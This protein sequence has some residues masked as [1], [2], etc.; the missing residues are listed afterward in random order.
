MKSLF[1]V[2]SILCTIA[3]Q[4]ATF[5][6][7]KVGNSS[8]IN[9]SALLEVQGTTGALLV[10]RMSTSQKNA[11]PSPADGDIVYDTTLGEFSGYQG[12]SWQLIGGGIWGS[13]TGTLSNQTDL[14]NALNLKANLASPTFTGTVTAPTF[15]G[16]LTGNASTSTALFGTPTGCTSGQ[17][18]E[19]I[20]SGANLTCAQVNYSQLTGVL[21]NPGPSTLGGI[22]SATGTTHEWISSI[23]TLGVPGFTQP[24][25]GDISGSL[26]SSQLP[27]P[28][29]LSQITTPSNPAS[30]SDSL[31][32]KSDDNLY[33][34]NSS[35][36]ERL[37]GSGIQG[38]NWS[39]SLAIVPNPAAFGTITNSA[40][41][42]RRIG[43]TLEVNGSFIAGTVS[44]GN[45]S[46]ALPSGYV[47]DPTKLN[48]LTN[49]TFLG[50]SFGAVSGAN[51]FGVVTS[52]G[53]TNAVFY[54]GSDTSNVYITD[55]SS[56]FQFTKSTG[57][58]RF[59]SGQL[60][61]F[62]FQIPISGWTTQSPPVPGQAGANFFAS[63]IINSGSSGITSGTFTTFSNSPAFTITPTITG[64]YKVYSAIS[65]QVNNSG[66]PFGVARVYETSQLA[67]LLYES[68][69]PL[70][71]TSTSIST[72][73]VQSVYTLVAG[74]TYVFD[75]QGKF[76]SGN[77]GISID[78]ADAPF[79]MF[80]ELVTG[81]IGNPT[82][83]PG[84]YNFNGYVTASDTNYWSTTASSLSDWTTNGTIPTLNI[85]TNNNFGTVIQA[86][87]Q[88]P[89]ITIISAPRTGVIRV[90]A[91][92]YIYT[93]SGN[94]QVGFNLLETGTA[95]QFG[96]QGGFVATSPQTQ[97]IIGYFPATQGQSYTF[98]IQGYVASG[99]TMFLGDVAIANTQLNWSMEYVQ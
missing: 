55:N 49:G 84:Q 93:P 15:A 37:V 23:S 33:S 50:S 71:T 17:Y 36:S 63:S 22:E 16:A 20:D 52:S 41:F 4:A 43:D 45:A 74:T 95:T 27:D 60:I 26:T 79:Y 59:N 89:A 97:V 94:A 8:P 75:L 10:P 96:L 62:S 87:S 30:G 35:G 21:P 51:P 73:F 70:F 77:L 53:I 88:Q 68:Q 76:L 57:S 13:I 31:Y 80:A 5:T 40:I 90:T 42:S 14:Q 38:S 54:D 25:F 44:T 2:Y 24:A 48:A 29:T 92:L 34:L 47:I 99:V 91:I 66:N 11:I 6:T 98:E 64:T 1:I 7:L 18:A 65:G 78:G 9:A 46:F 81:T 67:T 85:I 61:S 39:T 3:V 12:G 69:S 19:N 58:G 56:S 72:M 82:A 83:A 32:F 28:L 86:A